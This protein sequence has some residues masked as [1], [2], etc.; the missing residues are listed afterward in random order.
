MFTQSE[1][2]VDHRVLELDVEPVVRNGDDSFICTA[3]IFHS[4]P[5]KNWEWHLWRDKVD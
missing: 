5:L 2:H 3:K 1:T 4:F